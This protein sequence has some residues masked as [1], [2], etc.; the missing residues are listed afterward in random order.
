MWRSLGQVRGRVLLSYRWFAPDGTI[1]VP[2]GDIAILPQAVAPGDET[3]VLAGLWTPAEPGA[4]RLEW[5]MLC[6]WVAW[7]SVRGVPPLVH[8]VEVVDL[9]PRPTAPHFPAAEPPPARP[10]RRRRLGRRT[11]SP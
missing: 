3:T 4:Y 7:F 1:V 5:D 10:R 2:Q 8:E 11:A 6:E 9:G